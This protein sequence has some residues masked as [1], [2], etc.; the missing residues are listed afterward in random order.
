MR[1]LPTLLD[2]DRLRCNNVVVSAGWQAALHAGASTEEA[3][4]V[5]ILALAE[6]IE[7]MVKREVDGARLD[8]KTTLDP[9][10]K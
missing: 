10:G 2:F 3:Y 9:K 7:W 5:I 4:L 8:T 6:Q 1:E